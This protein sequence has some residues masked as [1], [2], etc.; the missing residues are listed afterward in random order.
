MVHHSR[1]DMKALHL[2][3]VLIILSGMPSAS[4][5][6]NLAEIFNADQKGA[7]NAILLSTIFSILTIPAIVALTN[8]TL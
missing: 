8:V 2:L 7:A 5:N 3:V 6:L 1:Q 4:F